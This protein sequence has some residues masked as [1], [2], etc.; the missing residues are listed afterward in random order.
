M[1]THLTDASVSNKIIYERIFSMIIHQ[2]NIEFPTYSIQLVEETPELC[3]FFDI[4]T[5]GLSWKRSHLYLLG[6]I[7]FEENHWVKKLWFCQKPSEESEVLKEFSFLLNSRKYLFHFNGATFDIPY[8][9]H[10]Y[11]FYQLEQSWEHLI[12]KDLYQAALPFK[13]IWK[14][15]QM[16]QK[17]LE[18]KFGINREDPY[19]G[20]DLIQFYQTYLTTGN[21]D[22]LNSLILHNSEDMDGLVDLLPILYLQEIF[23]GNLK[24][25][26]TEVSSSEMD[27]Q[28]SLILKCTFKES[29]PLDFSID[30]KIYQVHINSNWCEMIIPIFHGTKKFFF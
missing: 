3:L 19:T 2:N 6:A 17:D 28:E 7:F 27:A 13:K 12:S 26:N 10:K 5:T 18:K 14:M 23:Q 24:T 1:N 25:Q 15:E 9:M 30:T 11:T 16:K 29:L 21:E 4:E 20:G 22:L 8:L